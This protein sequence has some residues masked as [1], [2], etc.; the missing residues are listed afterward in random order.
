MKSAAITS[1]S[2]A[3]FLSAVGCGGPDP[4]STNARSLSASGSPSGSSDAGAPQEAT[5]TPPAPLPVS[6]GGFTHAA[7]G[8]VLPGVQVCLYGG[9]TVAAE[10]RDPIMCTVSAT[11]GSFG[12]SGTSA[13]ADVMLTFKKDGFAPTLRAITAQTA[14]LTLPASE[15]V[16]LP[17]PLVFMGKA[18]DPSKGH[19]AFV[20][21]TTGAGPAQDVSVTANAFYVPSG[22]A[23]PSQS[24]VYFDQN[25]VPAPGAATGTSGGFVNVSP[26]LYLV[27]F[28][29]ASGSCVA[30]S[31]LYG[32]PGTK[33]PTLDAAVLVP[34]IQGYVSAPIGVSC[35]GAR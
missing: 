9:I 11:D 27:Q 12:V 30:S 26:G 34:I 1:L 28:P 7:D 2:V 20:T 32:Y 6:I 18:A 15:N 25:G 8:S 3:T 4:S 16:L 35:T 22:V 14:D 13:T 19:I 21:T 23:W 31:G 17:D 33:D 24:P 5:N 29:P 10:P